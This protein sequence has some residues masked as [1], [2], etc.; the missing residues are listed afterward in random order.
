[1][2]EPRDPDMS[3]AANNWVIQNPKWNDE[4]APKW[5]CTEENHWYVIFGSDYFLRMTKNNSRVAFEH[6]CKD[7][8]FYYLYWDSLSYDIIF[9]SFDINEI[10]RFAKK[11]ITTE[12]WLRSLFVV[13]IVTKKRY[14]F[15]TEDLPDNWRCHTFPNFD[16][17]SL[18]KHEFRK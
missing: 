10:I 6:Y 15:V 17:I 16:T 7:E 1:M 3:M 5:K 14:A 11:L 4:N 18:G 12:T 13:D 2:I 9:A 8:H